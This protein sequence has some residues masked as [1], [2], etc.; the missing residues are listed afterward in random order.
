MEKKYSHIAM[1]YHS[2]LEKIS[3]IL[4]QKPN[5]DMD[6]SDRVYDCLFR[7]VREEIQA[8]V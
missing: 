6:N 7:V 1:V 2:D 5:D 3:D 8:R 4:D